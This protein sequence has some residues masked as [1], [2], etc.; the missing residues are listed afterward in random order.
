M[1]LRAA[2]IGLLAAFALN[3]AWENAQA[4]LFA[5]YAGPLRHFWSCFVGT[6]GDLVIVAAIYAAVALLWRDPAWYRRMRLG[7]VACSVALGIAIAVAIEARALA[8]G[9]WAYDGMPLVPLTEIGLLPVLQM[10][11]LP[12]TV[13][14]LM[15]GGEGGRRPG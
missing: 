2:G 4:F 3:L 6:L 14:A 9:R 12:P 10:M 11:I 1:T 5:G 13:F 15:G 8:S 7:Q